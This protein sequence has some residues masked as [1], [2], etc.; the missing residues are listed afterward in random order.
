MIQELSHSFGHA[1]FHLFNRTSD[2]L[3]DSLDLGMSTCS[4]CESLAGDRFERLGETSVFSKPFTVKLFHVRS[5]RQHIHHQGEGDLLL[6]KGQEPPV[7]E[8]RKDGEYEH[9][10]RV[11][12][13]PQAEKGRSAHASFW[14]IKETVDSGVSELARDLFDEEKVRVQPAEIAQSLIARRSCPNMERNERLGVSA[15]ITCITHQS[16]HMPKN[17][18][19]DRPITRQMISLPS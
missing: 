18:T 15:S 2:L 10:L 6:D 13:K 1:V 12:H 17:S 4:F 14:V 9:K 16:K 11:A 5:V 3:H 8:V 19:A 7:T